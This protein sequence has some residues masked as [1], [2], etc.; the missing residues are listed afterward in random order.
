MIL[1]EIS[2]NG[3]LL[4]IDVDPEAILRAKNF[5]HEY[6]ENTILVRDNFVELGQ[7]LTTTRFTPVHGI[8]LDL[9]W[10][11]P[12]FKDRGRGFSF[13]KPDEPLD[14]RLSK[15]M[16]ETAAEFLQNSSQEEIE[17]VLSEFGEEPQ[18]Q[19]I[20]ESIC[21]ARENKPLETVGELVEI[22]LQVYRK[23]LGTD[24]EVPWIGGL[25]PATKTFQALRIEVNKE[26]H[27]LETVL[28]Q[29]IEAL[30]PGGRLLVISFHSLEDRMVKHFFKANTDKI[31][32]LTKKPIT[33][34]SEEY[35]QNPPSRSA[36]LR[37]VQKK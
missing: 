1:K 10:S 34:A 18:A 13:N 2:P 25:H 24:K 20:A 12:Q 14:M 27:V 17:K 36:K 37:V 4:G 32:I 31:E 22:I 35:E 21:Q 3:K 19:A 8:L 33:A 5:L 23:K 29:A 15:D 28:P 11:T 9:G 16:G 30:T 6:S 26:L 7:I